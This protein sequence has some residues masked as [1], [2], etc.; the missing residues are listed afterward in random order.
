MAFTVSLR[1]CDF[2]FGNLLDH[3]GRACGYVSAPADASDRRAR[4]GSP[5]A[6]RPSNKKPAM[7]RVYPV[8]TAFD[9]R[10]TGKP[11]ENGTAV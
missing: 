11:L 10:R 5:D 3:L 9:I 7:C 1:D 2:H 8:P 6:L 4:A